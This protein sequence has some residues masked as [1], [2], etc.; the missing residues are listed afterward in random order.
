METNKLIGTPIDRVDGLLKVTGKAT[1]ATDYKVDHMAYACIFK[2]T[3][4]A[5]TITRI[6]SAAAEK[7]PGVLAVI[8]HLNAPKLN[9]GG[10]LR[11]GA[12]LQGPEVKFFGQHIGVIVAETFE[13]ASHAARLVKV[14]YQAS[15]ARIDFD[16]LKA[17]A[18]P[19]KEPDLKRGDPES[20]FSNGEFT[21]DEVYETPVEHHHPMEPHATVAVW[22][23]EHLTLYNASQIV[24]GAQHAAANT[25]NIKAENVRIVSPFIGGGFG[26]KG[27]QW[28]NLV[29]AAVAARVVNR[30]VQLAL[31][32]QQ[33]FN[34]VGLRQRNLQR[35]RLAANK[36]GKLLALAHETTTHCAISDEFVEPCG[37]CSKIMYEAPNSLITYRVVPMNMIIP[38]YTRGPGK[39]TGSFALESAIDELA[40]RLNMDPIEFRLKNEPAKDPSN[41]K[42]WSSRKL[43]ECLKE[44]AKAF[45]WEKRNAQPGRQQQGDYLIGYGVGCGTYPA[46]QQASSA[47]IKLTRE[48]N[49]I[50]ATVE[51]AAADLG[52][53]THTILAQTAADGLGLPI[54]Q[55][56]IKIGDSD[57]PPAAGSVG[58]VGATSYANAVNDACIKITD[59][60][61]TRTGKQFSVRPT[62]ARLMESEQINA[63]Q[64]RAD[65]KAPAGAAGYSSHSFSANFAEVWVSRSTGMATVKRFLSVTAAGKI[66]NL[67]T[68]RSQIIGGNT[69]GIGMALTEESVVDPRWG[70]FITRSFADYHVPANLDIGHMETIFIR[71]EDVIPNKMGIKGIGEIAI[72]GVA[73]AVAN[74]IFNATGKRIRQLPITPDKLL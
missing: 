8:T 7:I 3:I 33:M 27:G 9:P 61:I 73:A 10:G 25:L 74:A 62:A 14:E 17:G 13:Q 23:G 51:L 44:G 15:D 2:S 53:G 69:W 31:N 29:L 18:V 42:P 6:D 36:D 65:A 30:P 56:R 47:I 35:M 45:G 58:S 52:T 64:T 66:L 1:Y 37:D 19:A 60:L 57:L 38:T 68:A 70:N 21:L 12:L 49:K 50:F 48:G 40:F 63:F 43:V 26:S 4:A 11:G 22:E 16:K 72:V 55:V 20:A 32:R 71:E 28:A 41:D 54:D 67:K 24:N 5:G 39:A 46:H 34:S 59:E